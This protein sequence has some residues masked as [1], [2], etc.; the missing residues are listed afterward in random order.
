MLQGLLVLLALSTVMAIASF[1]AGS[2]PLSFSLSPS[3]M[4]L[5]STVGMGVLVGT[6][7]I[8]IIPEGVETLYSAS[9]AGHA[10]KRRELYSKAIHMR[11]AP[12]VRS[13]VEGPPKDGA[14]AFKALPGPVIPAG[15]T[16]A[17]R[18][19]I[20]SMPTLKSHPSIPKDTSDTITISDITAANEDHG[21]EAAHSHPSHAW[22]GLSLVLGFIL[23]YLIDQLPHHASAHALAQQGPYHIS[24]QNLSRGFHRVSSSGSIEGQSTFEETSSAPQSSS[25]SLSTT[26]GLVIHS[27]ADGIALGASSATTSTRLSLIIFLAIMIHKAPAAFG[28]TSVLLRQGFTKREARAHLIVFSLAAPAGALATWAFIHL[29]GKDSI[30]GAEGAKYTGVLLLFSAGTFLYVAMHQ[31]QEDS[32][33]HEEQ[34]SNGYAESQPQE[35]QGPTMRDT[36][37]A[38]TGMLLPL[39]TLLFNHHH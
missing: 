6:S 10:H 38:V 31:M 37:A 9:E 1:L 18:M 17:S 11:W 2:L 8:V 7:L 4:R 19:G 24:L 28:L 36:L 16:L 33:G 35:K 29:L 22:I 12:G 39:V 14:D 34:H 15:V 27:A 30:D 26:I 32:S 25:R 20:P 23:M 5:I 21:E 3:Q 13:V